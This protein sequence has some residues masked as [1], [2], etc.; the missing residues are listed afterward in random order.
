V[1]KRKLD[2]LEDLDGELPYKIARPVDGVYLY[3]FDKDTLHRMEIKD[4]KVLWSEEFDLNHERGREIGEALSTN[5]VELGEKPNGK[6]ANPKEHF[7]SR[8]QGNGCSQ[9][10][11]CNKESSSNNRL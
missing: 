5:P 8:N 11:Y 3:A 7:R 9:V 2:L 10:D 1:E 4:R 6:D